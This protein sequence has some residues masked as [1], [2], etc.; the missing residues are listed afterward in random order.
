MIGVAAATPA[1]VAAGIAAAL[2]FPNGFLSCVLYAVAALLL[3]YCVALIAGACVRKRRASQREWLGGFKVRTVLFACLAVAADVAY[4]GF[5]GVLAILSHS[6]WH[7][8]LAGYYC[9]LTALRIG[10]VAAGARMRRLPPEAK[11]KRGGAVLCWCG[12]CLLLFEFALGAAIA[13]RTVRGWVSPLWPKVVAIVCAAYSFYK[14]SFGIYNFV[15][16]RRLRDPLVRSLRSVGLA[17]AFSSMFSLQTTL[18]AVFSN[19]EDVVFPN[20]I[21][22]GAVCVLVA[23]LAVNCIVAGVCLSRDKEGTDV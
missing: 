2:F 20:A 5:N 7:G 15:K 13:Q 10:I 9:A 14:L 23:A 6:V 22:G 8:A 19:G 12:A 17:D 3:G 11:E 18:L 4:A 16:A 21:A 1:F